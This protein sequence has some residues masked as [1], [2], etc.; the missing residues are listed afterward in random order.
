[1]SRLDILRGIELFYAY[2][3][4]LPSL[5]SVIGGVEMRL[6]KFLTLSVCAAM[7]LAVPGAAQRNVEPGQPPH[8]TARVALP[9][10][11]HA[12]HLMVEPGKPVMTQAT[13]VTVDGKIRSVHDGF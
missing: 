5:C 12:G 1:E 2:S 9:T 10:V 8:P 6:F 13:L 3:N 4:R 7:A 11:I